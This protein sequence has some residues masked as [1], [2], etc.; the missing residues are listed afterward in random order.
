MAAF[1]IGAKASNIRRTAQRDMLLTRSHE[2][3]REA[4]LPE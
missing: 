2:N 3:Y 1:S 4:R